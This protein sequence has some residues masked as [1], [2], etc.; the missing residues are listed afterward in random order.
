[1]WDSDG[2]MSGRMP[3]QGTTA[4]SAGG[5]SGVP[6]RPDTTDADTG[7]STAASWNTRNPRDPHAGMPG[8][9]PED[10]VT[11]GDEED[12]EAELIRVDAR[13]AGM[14]DPLWLRIQ[15]RKLLREFLRA[16]PRSEPHVTISFLRPDGTLHTVTRGD[17]ATAIDRM[18]PRLRQILRLSVEERWPRQRVCE[19]LRHISIKTFERDQAEGLDALIDGEF[20]G[21]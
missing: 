16:V 8:S 10:A 11:L 1:M 4:P 21:Y 17:L 12:L 2:Q 18:R 3:P 20:Q 19:Y 9:V 13:G 6:A 15:A 5:S 7:G 14:A